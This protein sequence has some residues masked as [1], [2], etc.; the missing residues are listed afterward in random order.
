MKP[1]IT[2]LQRK[3][4]VLVIT[5]F[6]Y[7]TDSS[8][9]SNVVKSHE[10]LFS[11]H[12]YDFVCIYPLIWT[13]RVGVTLT[14]VYGISVNGQVH[15]F[16][17]LNNLIFQLAECE[18]GG[19][20]V[21]GILIHHVIYNRLDLLGDFLHQFPDTKK[22]FYLHDY[23]T[24]CLSIN[25]MR[26]KTR[27]AWCHSD[28]KSGCDGCTWR[29]RNNH[30]R[31]SIKE[32]FDRI[33]ECEFIAPSSSVAHE[34]QY[35]NPLGWRPV[36][37]IGHLKPTGSV[38]RSEEA[39]VP[40]RVAFVG[41]PNVNKGWPEFERLAQRCR[42]AVK[43]FHMG[44]TDLRLPGVENVDVQIHRQGLNA[45]VNALSEH[46]IDISLLLSG[47]L[48]TYS[49]TLFE[50]L[51]AKSLVCCFK[52]SGNVADVIQETGLGWSF[53]DEEALA[54]FLNS[55]TL[56][57]NVRIKQQSAIFP[58]AMVTNDAVISCFEGNCPSVG[59]AVL[60]VRYSLR[61]AIKAQLTAVGILCFNSMKTTLKT[62]L[63]MVNRK[64]V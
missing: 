26:D 45:M 23:W 36:R 46:K 12:G 51:Q 57:D 48:E 20:R 58:Q 4:L 38:G 17:G 14:G 52:D 25:M 11:G 16:M 44:H 7:I 31:E 56:L 49:Y 13:Y 18:R 32:F 64:Y 55:E 6:N 35:R 47:W 30:H 5:G 28:M 59:T 43:L 33:G 62:V 24:C 19:H 37:V 3:R 10:L 53:Q 22:V 15:G 40:V 27:S 8:G 54:D 42:G 29:G 1:L 41:A 63:K 21:A 2:A 61:E 34:W 39:T 60:S 9:T 50:S